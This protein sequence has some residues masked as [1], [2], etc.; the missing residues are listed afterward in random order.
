MSEDEFKDFIQNKLT[1]EQGE[2]TLRE[3]FTAMHQPAMRASIT[4][5]IQDF[6][7]PLTY[8]Q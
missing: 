1:P 6:T 4:N 3:I 5:H 8:V 2:T 7:L